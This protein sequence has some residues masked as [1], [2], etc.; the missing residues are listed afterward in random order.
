MG[1]YKS[2]LQ[3]T[4]E[5]KVKGKHH[6]QKKE[7]FAGAPTLAGA[8]EVGTA[9]AKSSVDDS[10]AETKWTFRIPILA[11]FGGQRVGDIFGDEVRGL[12]STYNNK[13]KKQIEKSSKEK[14]K[15]DKTGKVTDCLSVRMSHVRPICSE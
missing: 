6:T 2:R 12:H 5:E 11:D 8:A 3:I 7:T 4:R 9:F 1:E 13:I 14:R 10:G 15:K